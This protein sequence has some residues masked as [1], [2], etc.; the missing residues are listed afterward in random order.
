MEHELRTPLTSMI[1]YAEA[2]GDE[3]AGKAEGMVTDFAHSIA[4]SG[5]RLVDTLD[6][7]MTLA[8]L[9][10]GEMELGSDAVA[11]ETL[12]RQVAD[13]MRPRA[14]EAEVALEVGSC[15]PAIRV[16]ASTEGL[17]IVLRHLVANAIKFTE[18][19]G[20]VWVRVRAEDT[21]VMMEVEDTGIGMAPDAVPTLFEPFRQASEGLQR[22]YE[23]AGVG[24]A[25][26]QR[27]VDR[28]GGSVQVE[29]A[30]GEGTCF[31]VQ[32]PRVDPAASPAESAPVLAGSVER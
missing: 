16:R 13:E 4:Q 21:A 1:G 25:V 12:L 2:I 15:D 6:G 23:G 26:V 17:E 9:E 10:A 31:A 30:P 8:K 18:A 29:T 7:V 27:A 19:G 32:L 5:R 24:L 28:M 14:K 22:E 3:A 20:T 11:P